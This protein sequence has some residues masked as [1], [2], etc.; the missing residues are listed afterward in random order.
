MGVGR[1]RFS[2]VRRCQEILTGREVAVKFV[3]RRKQHR[4]A[5]K[6]EFEVL[7]RL[8]HPGLVNASGLFT[9][10]NSDAI[11]MDLVF[12]PPLLDWLCA[13]PTY[14]EAVVHGYATQ[15][16]KLIEYIVYHVQR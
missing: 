2:V 10:I 3:N 13:S 11:V 16:Q 15:V 5:S 12:G 6:R 4:E 14:T 7:R 9:T 1:G 8:A